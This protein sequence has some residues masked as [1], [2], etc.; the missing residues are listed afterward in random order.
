MNG[1]IRVARGEDPADLLFTGA[2]IV[3][4]FTGRIEE[5]D[6]AVTADR[7]A[8][9]GG[10]T[11]AAEVV[12]LE[13]RYL[14]PALLNGH[15]HPESSMLH[16]SRYAE[17]LVPLGIGGVVT[18]LHEIANVKGLE[19]AKFFLDAVRELPLDIHFMV[20]SC[21]PA[22]HME[23]AGAEI[24]AKGIAEALS[25]P[26][27]VGL[28]EVMNFPGV[29]HE[30]PMVIKKLGAAAGRVLDGHAPGL[31]GND[32]NAYRAAGIDSD[33]ECTRLEEAREKLARGM[34]I[35][36]REGSSEKN[37]EDLLPLVDDRTWKRCLFVVDDRNCG[38]LQRDGDIDAVVRKAIALGLDPVR[39]IA[40]ATINTAERFRL[41]DRGAVA[42][43]Y[44]ADLA[45]LDDL[46]DFRVH[47]V[48][49]QGRLVARD[50]QP[51]FEAP[52]VDD[53]GMRDSMNPAPLTLEDLAIPA[54]GWHHPVIGIIP[55]QIVTE[56]LQMEPTVHE[57]SIAADTERDLL[58]LVVVE[59]HRGTGNV[60]KG[61]VR[62]MGLQ[63]GALATSVGHDSHNIIAIG[64]RDSDLLHAVE[65][66]GRLG[67]G[68]V[69]VS[70]GQRLATL[71][72]PLAGLL[73]DQ[74][75]ATVVEQH[76]RVEAAARELGAAIEA[77]FDMLSF[78]ALAVIPE[79]KLTDL[80]LVDVTEF[81][82]L[83]REG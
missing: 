26:E 71:P 29:I 31:G 8:G 62:G 57:G 20:P 72:L 83:D 42:P 10:Y 17:V 13:G 1:L 56:K 58:K 9:V 21:V 67:G 66:V 64:T 30:D 40:M 41:H 54:S 48:Y 28:G 74:P 19:G 14:V 60:G 52:P 81:R 32:L 79:L 53:A 39:A 18:D 27:A 7:I 36:I 34:Y 50:G 65:E 45:V 5:G 70:G 22:T 16:P 82:L 78:L 73:S 49:H 55:G 33:H 38:D 4:V 23:T 24:D 46:E 76:E 6:V 59:R 77:P 80:G 68:L 69:A 43:G 3:N 47:S 25:W 12:D 75:L 2:R 15:V 51:L 44:R 61:L 63:R 37:L 11:E 35:M